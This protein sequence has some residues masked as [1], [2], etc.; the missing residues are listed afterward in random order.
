M[1]S[2]FADSF[3]VV[4]ETRSARWEELVPHARD[5]CNQAVSA[6][7]GVAEVATEGAEVSV[8]LAD[9]LFVQSLNK[10]WRKQDK[11]TNVLAFPCAEPG[12]NHESVHLLGDIVV[13]DSVV[14][15]EA[16]EQGKTC[17]QHLAHMVV[18]GTLHLLGFDHLSDEKAQDMEALETQ[19]LAALNIKDPY[20]MD[21]V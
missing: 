5:L 3:S 14:E 6:A 8:V 16:R 17:A 10:S 11:P 12:A 21:R 9:N 2:D 13:A 4:V 1:T 15:K 19:A 20:S 18:H 7:F